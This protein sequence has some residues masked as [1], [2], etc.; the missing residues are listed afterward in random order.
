MKFNSDDDLFLKETL[1]SNGIIIVFR[2][3]SHKGSKYCPQN[4]L[5][6]CL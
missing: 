2:S 5:D 3:D 4:F 6:E 1:E